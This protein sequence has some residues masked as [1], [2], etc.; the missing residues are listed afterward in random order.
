MRRGIK[1]APPLYAEVMPTWRRLKKQQVTYYSEVTDFRKLR[2]VVT[3][4]TIIRINCSD[5]PT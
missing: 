3:Q 5:D 2:K 1:F 4:F